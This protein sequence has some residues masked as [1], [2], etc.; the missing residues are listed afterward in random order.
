M[1]VVRA[2]I[3]RIGGV[4][5]VE[6]Q[7]RPGRPALH[8]RAADAD[9]HPG[10]RRSAPAAR[11]SR[12]RARR[13]RRSSAPAAS[14][15]RI[16]RVGERRD[17]DGPR[18]ARA[19]G[20][21]WPT[22]SASRRRG[23]ARRSKLILLK[24]AGGDV[25][26]LA[27]DAV[28]DHEELVVK[29]AAPAVMAAGLYAGTTL[30]DDGTPDAAARSSGHRPRRPASASTARG[31]A[32]RHAPA[33]EAAGDARRH[34]CCCSA[35]STA[36]PRR[37]GR[38]WSSGSRTWPPRRSA[39][40]PAGSRRGR[41]AGSC[42]WPAAPSAPADGKLRILRLT[43]GAAEIAYGFAEVIDI[44]APSRR[45]PA[46]RRRRA[47][48]PAS[49]LIDG[50]Q[51]ELLDPHW[52][53]AA[54]PTPRR[55]GAEPPVCALPAGDPWMDNILGPLIESAGYR[56]VAAGDGDRRRHRDRRRRGRGDDRLRRAQVVRLRA[57]PEPAD[58]DDSI[59]RYDRAALLGAL[60]RG[61]GR[62]APWLSCCSSS[63]SPAAASPFPPP[64]SKRWSS[65]RGSRRCRAPPPHVAGLVG[66]AQP[67][68]DRDRLPRRAR[69][70]PR[71]RRTRSRG[72]RRAVDGH[73]LCPAGRGGR[74][75]RRG[76]RRRPR[77]RG[78]GSAP[79][80][81][82]VALGMVEAEGDLLLL[83]DPHALIAGPAARR[84]LNAP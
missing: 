48:W 19:A 15:V 49:L 78:A 20:R 25:Y 68:A 72:G 36:P 69:S 34:R 44:V 5:E 46:R 37:A 79:G 39:S 28:H 4:V 71:R 52:L 26:A 43:D 24:P 40:A 64:R 53:F 22:C 66:A 41:R 51:V 32:R 67:G 3:E 61:A 1:D 11:S 45:R 50:E 14:A 70:R 75:R 63:A 12:F 60:S 65:S 31:R 84:G 82:R 29:P 83:V 58:E 30:A 2:N 74:G 42:R 18:P 23:R 33:R 6:S 8:P 47:R 16:D 9:H 27:V 10:A 21:A 80:W 57:R 7:A 76:A 56:V 35:P 55:D 81:D 73:Q 62:A 59:Y 17:R 13:S 77:R 54:M 38:R